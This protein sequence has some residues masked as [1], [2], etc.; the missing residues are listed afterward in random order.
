MR[1][2]V[3]QC[4]PSTESFVVSRAR[5]LGYRAINVIMPPLSALDRVSPAFPGYVFIDTSF[6]PSFVFIDGVLGCLKIDE[7]YRT[8]TEEALLESQKHIEKISAR[9]RGPLASLLGE[10]LSV[11]L[12][13]SAVLFHEFGVQ[14]SASVNVHRALKGVA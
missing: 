12:R 5:D 14:Y 1:F 13:S 9:P 6:D 8:V 4:I 11:I 10:D 7:A 2:L 3:V